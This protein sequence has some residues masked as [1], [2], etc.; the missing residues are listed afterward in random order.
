MTHV[1]LLGSNLKSDFLCDL[2][3][4]YDVQVVYE[5]DR[6]HEGIADE[7]HAEI[8]E[9]G[10]QFAF[11]ERQILKT[12]FMK[13]VDVTTFDPFGADQWIHTFATKAEALRYARNNGLTAEEGTAEFMG[14][15]KDWI[16][17]ESDTHTIHYE[18]VDADLRLITLQSK[19]A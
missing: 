12:L 18:F 11:D 4:T 10:L 15:Q 17:F 2:F 7:Y 1:D 13:P 16:R 14:E 6:T 19:N 8:K 9:L 5:Y 3:E